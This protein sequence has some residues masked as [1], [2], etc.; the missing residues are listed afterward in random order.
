[1]SK[2]GDKRPI[3]IRRKKVVHAHHGGAW[4]IALA[5][6][7]TAL[8]AFFLVLWLLSVSS[9]ETRKGVAEYFSTP[10][11]TAITGGDRSGSTSAIPGGGPDPTHSDGER[12]RI[13]SLQRTRP[14]M[15]ERNFFRDLQERIERAIERD[16]ELRQLRNQMRFD[17]T[18]EGLRIQLL[19]T[20]QRPMFELG[21]DQVAPYMRSLLRTIAPLLNELPNELSISGHTDSVPYAGGYRGY[22]NWEL[23]N[24]RANA[25]RRELIAGGF[26]PGQLLRVSGFAD[27][28]L[29]PET[30]PTDPINRRIELVVLFPEIA[31]AIRNPTVMESGDASPEASI[32]AL[33]ASAEA[34]IESTQQD[35]PQVQAQE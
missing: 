1:M 29:L 32:E 13:D 12:A 27:R 25:S 22:S 23:S 17:L 7:M 15:Q 28:V 5:D 33:E 3:V 19:D 26:D 11:V 30:E 8:M 34:Q 6:F 20:D 10:L 21:S 14:S 16:P 24:D 18:R 9:E 31:D 2:G 4:K 35:E